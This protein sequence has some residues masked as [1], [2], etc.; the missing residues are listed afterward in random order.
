FGGSAGD[1][2]AAV[3][4]VLRGLRNALVSHNRADVGRAAAQHHPLPTDCAH[5]LITDPPYYDAIPYADLSDFFYV[6][7]RRMLH[8]DHPDL[9]Q[10]ELVPKDDECIVNPAA[11]KNS[12]YYRRV[13]TGALAEARRITRPDGIGVV[14]FATQ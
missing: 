7:L 4:H 11:G 10:S 12:E 13:M 6:W 14:I 9:F 5:L 2:D 8:K 3:E 1:W